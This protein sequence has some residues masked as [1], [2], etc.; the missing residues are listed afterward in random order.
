MN[1]LQDLAVFVVLIGLLQWPQPSDAVFLNP[2][3][4]GQVLLFPYYTAREGN[5]TFVS[6]VNTTDEAKALR[7]RFLEGV[8]SRDVLSFNLYLAPFDVWVAAITEQAEDGALLLT[9]DSS[10]TVPYYFGDDVLADGETEINRLGD[11]LFTNTS[12]TGELD[13]A[14]ADDI[15]RTLSGHV[16]IIEMGVVIDNEQNSATA[17]THEFQEFE[18]VGRPLPRPANCIQLVEAWQD[19]PVGNAYWSQ[20]PNVDLMPPSG[21]LRGGL[22]IINV[23][24]GVMFSYVAEAIDSFSTEVLHFSPTNLEPHLNSGD[25]RTSHVQ[26][27]GQMDTQTWPTVVEAVSALFMRDTVM[28]EYITDPAIGGRSEWVMTFPTKRFYTD[29]LTAIDTAPVA[30]FNKISFEDADSE[31]EPPEVYDRET[32]PENDFPR[33]IICTPPPQPPVPGFR[34][35]NSSNVIRFAG[36]DEPA[37]SEILG[38]PQFSTIPV[39]NDPYLTSGWT[40]FD[41]STVGNAQRITRGTLDDQGQSTDTGYIGLPVIGFWVNT[42][43]NGQLGGGNVLANYGGTFRHSGSRRIGSIPEPDPGD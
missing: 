11:V 14:G 6:V 13:D 30:P 2:D 19:S 20:D 39:S 5:D 16:E 10:C 17:L 32:Y 40:R 12:Y 4:Q 37:A 21:G 33:P 24:T 35:C 26:I 23:G 9:P 8:N 27:D 15:E 3:Q 42:F 38:E 43:T 36:P 41:F 7:V 18:G 29:D 22:T 34:L 31:I 25:V 28:N 1:T